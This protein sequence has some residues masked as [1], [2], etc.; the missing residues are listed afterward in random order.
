MM[1]INSENLSTAV[2]EGKPDGFVNKDKV[3]ANE[4][5]EATWQKLVELQIIFVRQRNL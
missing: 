3:M 5:D 1:K 4:I 2:L